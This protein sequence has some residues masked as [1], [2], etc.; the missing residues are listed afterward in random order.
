MSFEPAA[1]MGSSACKSKENGLH[2]EYAVPVGEMG[3]VDVVVS[4]MVVA[5][6]NKRK[7]YRSYLIAFT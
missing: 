7:A 1:M 6:V 3:I 4:V 2:D 5:S